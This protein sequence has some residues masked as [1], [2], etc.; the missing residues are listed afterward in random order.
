M[1]VSK[2]F[3]SFINS[4]LYSCF[5]SFCHTYGLA[6]P[7]FAGPLLRR[8]VQ[9]QI[10]RILKLRR[11]GHTVSAPSGARSG[12]IWRQMSAIWR[13]MEKSGGPTAIW[14]QIS[15]LA[16]ENGAIWCHLALSGATCWRCWRQK[17][18]HVLDRSPASFCI[19]NFCSPTFMCEIME[20]NVLENDS[21][22][23]F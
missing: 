3:F 16:P 10:S 21:K 20:R 12:A 14:R 5:C 7:Y 18:F 13:Q 6:F 19:Q 4:S 17:F 1:I 11:K 9:W 2:I 15:D 8:Y 23:V 22:Q